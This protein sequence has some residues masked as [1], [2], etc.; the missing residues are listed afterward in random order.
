MLS[1]SLRA[2]I[3]QTLVKTVD[4]SN[5]VAAF[6]VMLGT[7]AIR[8][9]IRENKVAQMYSTI[10]MSQALGMQTL[11]QSLADLQKRNLISLTQLRNHASDKHIGIV[12]S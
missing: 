7:P 3:S 11:D 9:L 2:V 5:R 8:N 6:E 10:Q 12:S 1:E 4:E